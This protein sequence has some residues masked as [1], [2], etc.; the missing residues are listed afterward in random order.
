MIQVNTHEAKTNL[1]SLLARVE[2]KGELIWICRNG[3]AIAELRPIAYST[4]P[5]KQDS[6]LKNVRFNESPVLPLS[7]EDWPQDAR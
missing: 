3:K 4:N 7:E 5:L 1:S 6:K 2:S